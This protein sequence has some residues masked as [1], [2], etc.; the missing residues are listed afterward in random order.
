MMCNIGQRS[1]TMMRVGIS[2]EHRIMAVKGQNK[3]WVLAV[4]VLVMVGLPF[5]LRE[6]YALFTLQFPDGGVPCARSPRAS[7]A[8]SLKLSRSCCWVAWCL[9]SLTLSSRRMTS[10]V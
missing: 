3:A 9:A 7:W 5:L 10:P 1:A 2:T 6:G 4:A 8:S